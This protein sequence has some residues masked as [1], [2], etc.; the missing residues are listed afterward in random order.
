MDVTG[1]APRITLAPNVPR[2]QVTAVTYLLRDADRWLAE[3]EYHADVVEGLADTLV[4]DIPSQWSEPFT[5]DRP[6]PFRIVDTGGQSRKQLVLY[7]EKPIAGKFRLKIRGRVALGAGDRLRVPDIVPQGAE[8]LE[9][10][11]VLP[12]HLDLQQVTWDTLGLTRAAL[13]ADFV[14]HAGNSDS[15][16]VF[17]VSAPHFQAALKNVARARSTIHARLADVQIA[18]Q[19]DGSC[20]GVAAFDLEPEGASSCVFELPDGYRLLHATIDCLPATLAVVE[21]QRWRLTLGPRQLPAHV[22]IVFA[23]AAKTSGGAR[24]FEAPRLL[25]VDVDTTLWTLNGPPAERL[26]RDPSMRLA[27][28]H[29]QDLDRLRSLAALVQLP[30]EMVGEHLAEEIVRWYQ[31]WKQRY[32]ACRSSLDWNLANA[33]RTNQSEEL[34]EARRLDKQ[35]EAVDARIGAGSAHL[36][37]ATLTETAAWLARDAAELV[38]VHLVVRGKSP[39]VELRYAPAAADGLIRWMAAIAILFAG[40]FAATVLRNATLPSF[41]PA[42]VIGGCGLAWWLFLTPSIIGF[43]A[44]V[45]A[46]WPGLRMLWLRRFRPQRA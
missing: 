25:D 30:P 34:I 26:R 27:T 37:P 17:Q 35:V 28:A 5:I 3:L 38:P 20:Q 9:R 23:G 15:V 14:S 36:A 33:H 43:A 2:S 29:E 21:P 12:Q 31:P 16:A 32:A 24:R 10:F 7:P 13:P 39:S 1:D 44:L 19:V 40:M 45:A 18:W 4:F 11:V 46:C 42:L 41:A 8:Q 22:E 6:M